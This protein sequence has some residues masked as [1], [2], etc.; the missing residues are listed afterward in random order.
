MLDAGYTPKQIAKM[1]KIQNII[2]KLN[3]NQGTFLNQ[4]EHKIPKS[5]A[6]ELLNKK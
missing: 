2:R 6:V 5:V 1:D 4:L 3:L